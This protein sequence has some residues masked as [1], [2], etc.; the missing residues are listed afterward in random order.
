ME[1]LKISLIIDIHY[2]ANTK[3]YKYLI[4]S[5]HI[6]LEQ[7]DFHQKR[8]FS[9]RSTIAGAN[10]LINLSVPIQKGRS[11]KTLT[12]DIRI[13][14]EENWQLRHWRSI[15]SSYNNS[16]WFKYFSDDLSVV[17]SKRHGFLL[18][19]NLACFDWVTTKLNLG[20]SY[21]LT[22]EWNILP[23][24]GVIDLRNTIMPGTANPGDQVRYQQVFENK[25]G[26]QPDLSIL[27]LLFCE[28]PKSS[29]MLLKGL[30]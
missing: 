13:A 5:P 18:D 27:D 11:Q 12:R 19:W 24:A 6:V 29:V 26:F 17:F 1:S 16:P 20:M 4:R 2:F 3:Y 10:G 9:N 7:Y 21:K 30:G 14:N 8:S 23:G 15:L 22:R 28:G 25:I